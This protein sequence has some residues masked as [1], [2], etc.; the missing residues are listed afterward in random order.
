[1][2][3]NLRSLSSILACM[4]AKIVENLEKP[5]KGA[6]MPGVP[7]WLRALNGVPP[8]FMG[9][10]LICFLFAIGPL[11]GRFPICTGFP[12]GCLP[13]R[14]EFSFLCLYTRSE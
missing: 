14:F 1:M 3:L 2:K 4:D 10:R 7:C 6:I 11:T 5:G 8:P 13:T 9:M 12:N